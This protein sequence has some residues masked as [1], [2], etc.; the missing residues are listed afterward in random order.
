MTEQS[1]ET[2]HYQI[3]IRGQLD[4]IWSD[5]FDHFEILVGRNETL[6]RG[7]IADQ[8]ALFGVLLKIHDLGLTLLAINLLDKSDIDPII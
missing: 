2:Y 3:R 4:S 8:A 6:L 1:S 5:W 7:S